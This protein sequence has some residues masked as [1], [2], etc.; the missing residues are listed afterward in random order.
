[1]EGGEKM[2]I[3]VISNANAVKNQYQQDTNTVNNSSSSFK[4]TLNKLFSSNSS[5]KTEKAAENNQK[6]LKTDNSIQDNSS[7]K[8]ILS[9]NSSADDKIKNAILDA[10]KALGFSELDLA[11]IKKLLEDNTNIVQLLLMFTQNTNANINLEQLLGKSGMEDVLKEVDNVLGSK[12]SSTDMPKLKEKI[13]SELS[14]LNLNQPFNT[15]STKPDNPIEPLIKK[16]VNDLNLKVSNDDLKNLSSRIESRIENNIVNIISKNVNNISTLNVTSSDSSKDIIKNYLIKLLNTADTKN[17]ST[18]AVDVNTNLI[19]LNDKTQKENAN[20]ILNSSETKQQNTSDKSSKDEIFLSNLAG[21]DSKSSSTN[22]TRVTNLINQLTNT[23]SVNGTET[24]QNANPVLNA[25]NIQ[26]DFIQTLKFMNTNEL[27]QL[28][29]KVVPKELGEVVIN[30]TLQEGNF[31]ANITA[32]NKDAYNLL[33]ANLQDINSKLQNEN[34][35]IQNL[36][37]NVYNEDTTFFKDGSHNQKQH[38]NNHK[39]S[40]VQ[41]INIDEDQAS[42]NSNLMEENNN[43][44]LFA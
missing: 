18:E 11:K 14:N 3:S 4:N 8:V 43:V 25:N 44:N 32:A 2:E 36:T 17:E 26:E 29:V 33:N 40:H 42:L 41:N 5:S 19:Q 13:S 27:Q 28:T 37:L 22:F 35:K 20:L 30:L 1:M 16:A 38:E 9:K 39:G 23:N 31:K 7:I 6:N 24:T 10:A 21:N 12:L 15:E 34:I